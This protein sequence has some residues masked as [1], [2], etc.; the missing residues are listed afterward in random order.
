MADADI[1]HSKNQR[2]DLSAEFVRSLLDYDPLNGDLS[3]KHNL[4]RY[5]SRIYAGKLITGVNGA[6]YIKMQICGHSYLAHRIIWLM[7]TCALPDAEIDHISGDP[8]D[9]RWTNLRAATRSENNR[10]C[11]VSSRNTSGHKGVSW[12]IQD[13]KWQAHINLN[14]KRKRLGYFTDIKSAAAAYENSA[15][16]IFGEFRRH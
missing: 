9:N 16:E 8:L 11:K 12:N 13:K 6:G 10:N 4:A 7:M 1:T 15:A 3:W 14:G 2:N 5:N